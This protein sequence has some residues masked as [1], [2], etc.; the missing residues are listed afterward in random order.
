MCSGQGAQKPGMGASLL[1]EPIVAKVFA[2]ASEVF[3]CNVR[4][5][6]TT[7]D[8]ALLNDTRNAQI[9]TSTLSLAIGRALINNGVVP[10]AIVGFSL[11]Q[12][13]ALALAG[14]ISDEAMFNLVKVRA[15]L[16][17]KTADAHPGCMSALLKANAERVE[18]LCKQCSGNDVLVAA[19][20]NCPGQIVI[21]GTV[22]AVERAEVAWSEQGGRVARLATSGAFHSPLMQEAADEFWRYLQTIDFD[23]PTIPL[24]CNVD[25]LPLTAHTAREHLAKHLT[26]P[27][28]FHQSVEYLI[29]TGCT[30]FVEIGYGGVLA[31]LVKRIDKTVARC[32]VSDLDSFKSVVSPAV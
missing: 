25:A 7:S 24:I 16:M 14:M 28:L 19:N 17:G 5:L 8:A 18:E 1:D 12:I 13:P 6:C 29:A 4:E 3:G 22:S 9:A 32:C 15:Q 27:V 21:S 11:G 26:H 30:S 2:C 20:Y 31:N 23:E 10:Q